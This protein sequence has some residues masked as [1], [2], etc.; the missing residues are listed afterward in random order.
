MK[1]HP[2]NDVTARPEGALFPSRSARDRVQ[3]VNDGQQHVQCNLGTRGP[4]EY[5][6]VIGTVPKGLVPR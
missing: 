3:L 5:S 1:K 4:E 6:D 2:R